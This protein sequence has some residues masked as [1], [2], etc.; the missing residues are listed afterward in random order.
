MLTVCFQVNPRSRENRKIFK[1]EP[2]R[3]MRP[4]AISMASLKWQTLKPDH[5]TMAEMPVGWWYHLCVRAGTGNE[6]KGTCY[7]SEVM[8]KDRVWSSR[9][10]ASFREN[11]IIPRIHRRV[12]SPW[13]STP[14]SGDQN[15]CFLC[16]RSSVKGMPRY[17]ANCLDPRQLDLYGELWRTVTKTCLSFGSLFWDF[18]RLQMYAIHC[19]AVWRNLASFTSC[20]PSS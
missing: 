14:L 15:G 12:V 17:L 3:E 5:T 6:R 19:T 1:K 20:F 7:E 10:K 16:D 18:S 13:Q 8:G 2:S 9:L 11:K 4:E